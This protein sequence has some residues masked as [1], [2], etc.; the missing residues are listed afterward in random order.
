MRIPLIYTSA[1][2]RHG[3]GQPWFEGGDHRICL[4]MRKLS[5]GLSNLRDGV[6]AF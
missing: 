5:F 2:D 6:V 3:G 1:L 4:R